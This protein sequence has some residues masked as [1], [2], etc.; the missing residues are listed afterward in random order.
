MEKKKTNVK[1]KKTPKT[2]TKTLEPK[3]KIDM[4]K[5]LKIVIPVLILLVVILL[6]IF[7]KPKNDGGLPVSRS[8]EA[9]VKKINKINTDFHN[10]DYEATHGKYKFLAQY[11]KSENAYL[12]QLYYDNMLVMAGNQQQGRKIKAAAIGDSLLFTEYYKQ[13]IYYTRTIMIG[14]EGNILLFYEY[15]SPYEIKV[16]GPKVTYSSFILDVTKSLDDVIK[17]SKKDAILFNTYHY[18]LKDN[19]LILIETEDVTVEEY[20]KRKD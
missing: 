17:N 3:K 20:S 13:T 4:K 8:M 6:I 15:T 5:L 19:D 1:E 18:E 12:Y 14:K 11:D 16:D 2:K 7:L 9:Y 10:G